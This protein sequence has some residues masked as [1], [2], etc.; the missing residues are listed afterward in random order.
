MAYILAR[1][2]PQGYSRSLRAASAMDAI[3]LSNAQAARS[4]GPK[5]GTGDAD[6]DAFAAWA[7]EGD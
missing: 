4:A 5:K 7:G 3:H 6:L 2:S 1:R